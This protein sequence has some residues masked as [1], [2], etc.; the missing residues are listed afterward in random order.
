[1][2]YILFLIVLLPNIARAQDYTPAD[3][4]LKVVLLDT[5]PKESFLAVRADGMGRLFVGGRE[6][7]FVLEPDDKGGYQPRRE[8]YRFPDH[9]WVY[10]IEIRGHDLYV[11]TVTALY[12]IP[13]G[14][15]KRGKLEIEKLVWGVP[16]GH[17]H[18]CFHALAWGPEGDLYLSMGDPLWYYGDFNRPDHWGHWTFFT[19]PDKTKVPY[20]GVGGVF[21]C[22]PDGSGFQIVA[23]GLRNSCGLAFDRHF[24]LFSNDNDHEGLPAFYVPGRLVHVTPHSYFSWPR[25]WMVHKTPDRADLLETMS[26]TLGRYV[27]V[28]QA[29]YHETF[30]PEKYRDNLLVA[31]WCTGRIARYPLEARGASFKTTE[32]P[33]LVGKNQVR[34]V[35][36][37]VGRGGRIFATLSY[38]AHNE[39]S[40]VYKSD[41]VM[42]TRGDDKADHP[43]EAY[44]PPTAMADKLWRELSDPSWQSRYRAHQEILRRGGSLLEEAGKRL[45]E[46]KDD[47]PA[48]PHLVWLSARSGLGSLHLTARAGDPNPHIRLQAVR[49]LGEFPEQLRD[50]PLLAKRLMD[51]DPRVQQATVLAYYHPKVDFINAARDLIVKGPARSKDTYLRQPATLLL[52]QRAALKDIETLCANDDAAT[53]LAGVLAAGFRLTLPPATAPIPHVFPLAKLRSDEA[54]VIDYADGKV[55]LRTLGRVG[56]FT[57]ADHWKV[58]KHTV[59]QERLFEL[60]RKMLRA[61]DEPTRLQAAHFLFLLDDPRSEPDVARVRTA[62]AERRLAVV[63]LKVLSPIWLAGPFDDK[64]QGMKTIHP[65][66]QGAVDLEQ[67]YAEGN[68]KVS[69]LT[70]KPSYQYNLIELLGKHEHVS[71]YAYLRLESA[72]KEKAHLLVG[73]DDGIKVWHNGKLVWTKEGERAALPYQDVVLLDLEPGSNDL[74]VRVNNF[75]G[76]SALYLHYRSLGNVVPRLPEK[77]GVASL[78]KRLAEAGKDTGVDAK[79]FSVDWLKAARAGDPKKGRQLF[80]ALSCNK[81]HAV[82]MDAQVSGGPSLAD[83]EKRFTIPYLVESILLPGKQISPVFKATHLETTSGEVILGLVLNETAEKLEVLLPDATRKTLPTKQIAQ[84]RLVDQSPMPAGVVRTPEELR[85]LLAYLLRPTPRE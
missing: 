64:K 36:V 42:I 66:E 13:G 10:D 78:A 26:N 9:S 85:D 17:V 68:R 59:E 23:R 28:G 83:A 49:A 57:V 58:G 73:S 70:A 82:S 20:T 25:G 1:M 35:G 11:L 72:G 39:A 29:Y 84:R 4:E 30:L 50:F 14:V 56:N 8:L 19:G 81:C 7:L 45:H 65:P 61:A 52:A 6:A 46:A 38:M 63:P 53:R 40:P 16:M 48:V 44:D 3:P 55:D 32:E 18:Q 67:T 12:K 60:L 27:P 15:T 47:D 31:R 24:N 74:L 77:L 71:Y 34:P 5:D 2:R 62:S 51:D 69:W 54:Y 43:F 80:E 75:T 37:S 22:K 41:L 79:F 76:D 33:L 21:R